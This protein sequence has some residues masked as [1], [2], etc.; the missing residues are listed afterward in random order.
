MI[1]LVYR[2]LF[3]TAIGEIALRVITYHNVG[4]PTIA[5]WAVWMVYG[6]WSLLEGALTL[7]GVTA[8]SITLDPFDPLFRIYS[9]PI[10]LIVG[11][12]LAARWAMRGAIPVSIA[13]CVVVWWG[14]CASW[15]M[16][17]LC[18]T[19]VCVGAFVLL[20]VRRTRQ[21]RDHS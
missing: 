4:S 12:F 9:I 20:H 19:L 2:A 15:T 8:L 17:T 14:Y 21:S 10:L 11:D 16:L 6:P 3:L 1:S 5:W 7:C 13:A 18:G